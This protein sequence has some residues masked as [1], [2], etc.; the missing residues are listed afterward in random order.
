MAE[1][2]L[3]R[4]NAAEWVMWALLWPIAWF[5]RRFAGKGVDHG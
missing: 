2:N 3:H 5:I 1:E 4:K